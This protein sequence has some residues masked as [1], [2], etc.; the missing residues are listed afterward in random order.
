MVV[1]DLSGQKL[2]VSG[3]LDNRWLCE[4]QVGRR[5]LRVVWFGWLK[6]GCEWPGCLQVGCEWF[7]LLNS[8]L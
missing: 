1:R 3:L 5:W 7:C 6:D 2:V 8:W 4:I